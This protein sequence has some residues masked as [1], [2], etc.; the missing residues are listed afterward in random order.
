MLK[1]FLLVLLLIPSLAF[2]AF[3]EFYCQS[4]GSNLNAGSTT[5]NTAAYT[6][7]GDSD[8]ISK[9]TPSDGSTPASTVS[10]GDFA[11]IY[12]T[13]GA[14]VAVYISRVTI[15]AAGV[16]GAITTSTSVKTGTIPASSGTA[17]TITCKVGGAWPGPLGTAVSI[18]F[19]VGTGFGL[20]VNTNGDFVRLNL[21]NDQT[22]SITTPLACGNGMNNTI[23]QGYS[24][25][26][27]DARGNTANRA[28]IDGGTT[29]MILVNDQANAIHTW[30]DIN[31][32]HN[33]T[34]GTSNL[35]ST[36]L[37]ATTIMRCSFAHGRGAGLNLQSASNLIV[38]C[39]AYDNNLSNTS[40]SGGIIGINNGGSLFLRC[41]S[42]DNT[43]SN[44][45][46][47]FSNSVADTYISCIA[48]TNGANGFRRTATSTNAPNRFQ[49]CDAYNN[50]GDGI[51]LTRNP[52]IENC[53]FIKNGGYGINVT[54]AHQN[55]EVSN[56]GYGAGSMVNTT[57]DS[58][59]GSVI[60]NGKVTY[61]SGATPWVDP[62]NGDFRINNTQALGAG[63]GAFNTI[64]PS[65][66]GTVGYP[67]IGA[68]Q[69]LTGPGG[70]F[71]KQFTH[72]TSQ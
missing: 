5:N 29:A 59:L 30:K 23:I 55:G 19:N 1:R 39:E 67:D 14:T 70:T 47:F 34:T 60:E 63:R 68:A 16:N 69:S 21:K 61:A 50:V 26:P 8:G 22:Y 33:G 31:F 40:Q 52:Q 66:A 18:P 15:V 37:G 64:A 41:V 38:E 4:G 51:Q 45:D 3:T 56:C 9:F 12:V 13:A 71:T 6:G 28:T 48:D 65:Y 54:D 36:S 10:V 27:G 35:F 49:N 25:T 7:V 32:A 72:G 58:N 2:G 17:H 62:A 44:T 57:A 42:H 46:G 43:G 53:N 20:L 11:S 24:S